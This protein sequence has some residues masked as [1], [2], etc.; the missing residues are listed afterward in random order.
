MKHLLI[1]A[2]LIFPIFAHASADQ[3]AL[4]LDRAISKII[5]D[6]PQIRA[7]Q[8]QVQL[9][10]SDRW[11]R[12][13]PNEPQLNFVKDNSDRSDT[14]G[15]S[16]A[17]GF[18]GKAIALSHLDA[19]IL[20]KQRRELSAKQ[21]ELANLTAQSYTDC[22]AAQST[23]SIR[24]KTLSDLEAFL[25]SLK[26]R[27]GVTQ[28]DKLSFELETRQA[29]QDLLIAHDARDVACRKFFALIGQEKQEA[30]T[31]PEDLSPELIRSLAGET[32]E[33]S[34]LIATRDIAEA[35]ARTAYWQQMPDFNLSYA[36]KR[37]PDA[38]SG[39]RDNFAVY[40]VS[41][42]LP[43]LFPFY[44]SKEAKRAQ[45]QA[46]ID[47]NAADLQRVQLEADRIEA[48]RAFLRIKNYLKEIRQKNLP[49]GQ[50]LLESSYAAYRAGQV[51]Y[52]EMVLS[53]KTLIEL[54]LKEIDLRSQL[55]SAR[56]KCLDACESTSVKFHFQ[57][58]VD[59]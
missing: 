25:Q 12:F 2:L 23:I 4:T 29:H 56:L 26:A 53:R 32:A 28:T 1:P 51:G 55:I 22:A 18:P 48:A 49:L 11:R 37:M 34:R 13:I 10:E 54:R 30:L 5:G 39:S 47:R 50:A 17:V 24:E 45:S 59:Q 16:L 36:Q 41:V 44:E 8:T 38:T 20:R 9:S 33:E 15:L 27:R 14:W 43:L 40:G 21:H 42:T 3:P 19:A 31:L 58:S 35:T 46:T 57:E 52:A 7:Q 6:S